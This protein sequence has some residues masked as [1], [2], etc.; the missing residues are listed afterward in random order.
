MR[1]RHNRLLGRILLLLVIILMVGLSSLGCVEGLQPIGWSGGAVSGDTLFVGSKE[2]RLVAVNI[3]DESRQWSEPIK[4]QKSG[5]GFG[6]AAPTGGGGCAAAPTGVAIYGTPAVSGD[7]VY[8]GGYNGK[9]YAFSSSSLEV[10]W[11]YPR[12][13]YLQPIVGGLV[14]AQDKVY[15]GGS[16]GKVYALD[17]ATGDKQWEF[18]AEDMIWSTPAIDGDTLFFGSFDN[19]LY[20]LNVA[21]GSKKWEFETEG[22]IAATPLVYDNTVYIGSF[23]RYLYAVDA[24]NGGLRWRFMG[25]RWFWA[26][27]VAYNNTIYASCLDGK[28]YA[29][30]AEKGPNGEVGEFGVESPVSS[31]PIV[32]NGSIIF[33]S[34]K[35]VIY[36]LDTASSELKQL[37]DIEEEVYGPLCASEG[38][39]YI[40]TQELTLHRVNADTGAVLMSIS[41]KSKE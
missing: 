40:H 5:G 32:V 8:I 30:D 19:K 36:T 34:Q 26:K 24:T 4:A 17:A 12:E 22:A 37:A 6:C 35:G 39:V 23:D 7:L 20:A 2:G 13:D 3:A 31:S 29:L 14:V 18:E 1:F 21:D 28:V 27:P 9:I 41:L 25:E 15:F 38:V 16:D 11:V 33:A 10:R